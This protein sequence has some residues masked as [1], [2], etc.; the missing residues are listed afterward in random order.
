MTHGINGTTTRTFLL[1]TL[2]SLL[3]ALPVLAQRLVWRNEFT[4]YGDNTEFFTPFR[5]GETLLGG[6]FKSFLRL[7]TSQRTEVRAGVF[8]DQP[9]GSDEFLPSVKPILSFRYRTEHS[10][11]VLGML[12]TEGRHGLLEPLQV[13]TLEITRP[14]EYGFQWIER[15]ERVEAEFF[16]NW[17]ALNRPMNSEVFDAG[18]LLRVTPLPYLSVD[19]QG[20]WFHVGGQIFS[21][22]EPLSN[23]A[24][25]PG[26]R[27][28]A[29]L[30]W[31][32]RGA[33]AFFRLWSTTVF[34]PGPLPG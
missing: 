7:K 25:G 22:G 30:P 24:G 5:E 10:L 13:T 9:S 11:G 32:R 3:A 31:V 34:D 6:Q 15:R 33:L 23:F 12:E 20:H 28:T 21:Q 4:F 2:L 1:A 8:A 17:Q 27:L 19:V 29:E 26:L 18:I 16:L 14:I